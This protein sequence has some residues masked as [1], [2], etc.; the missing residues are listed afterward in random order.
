MSEYVFDSAE[1]ALKWAVEVLRRRRLPK[2]TSL[3][4]E[5]EAEA[6]WI[7]QA[8]EGEKNVTLPHDRDERM[9]LALKVMEAVTRSGEGARLLLLWAM[10]DWADEGRLAAAMAIQERCRREGMRVRLAYRY[11]YDQLGTV[12]GCDRKAAWRK[13]QDA[14]QALGLELTREGFLVAVEGGE[15]ASDSFKKSV[16]FDEFKVNN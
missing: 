16:Y 11:T 12:L 14:L 10:G 15:Q 5:I 7:G 13:V 9:H 6:E 1:H 2:L 4:R 3:W 8:W